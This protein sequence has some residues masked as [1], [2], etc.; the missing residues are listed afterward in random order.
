[1]EHSIAAKY[2]AR[3]TARFVRPSSRARQR[4]LGLRGS[5]SFRPAAGQ[6]T[7]LRMADLGPL[8]RLK[9]ASRSLRPS[10]PRPSI[11]GGPRP[12]VAM[13]WARSGR[14][15]SARAGAPV[16]PWQG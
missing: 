15:G 3:P 2:A 8:V 10:R 1:M 11:S 9:A 6:A 12:A 5:G 16:A 14:S 13:L 4:R 7:V